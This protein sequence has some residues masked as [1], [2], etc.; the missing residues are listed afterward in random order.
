MASGRL[1]FAFGLRGPAVSVDTACSASL[2]ALHAAQQAVAGGDGE[3]PG[4]AFVCGAHVQCTPASTAYVWKVRWR[5]LKRF[6]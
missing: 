1:A 3:A 2:V 4:G 5:P 6:R